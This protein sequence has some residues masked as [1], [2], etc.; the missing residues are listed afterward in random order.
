LNIH[1][2]ACSDINTERA[3]RLLLSSSGVLLAITARWVRASIAVDAVRACPEGGADRPDTVQLRA[4]LHAID[5]KHARAPQPYRGD[6]VHTSSVRAR[7]ARPQYGRR[8]P[9][10]LDHAADAI[11]ELDILAAWYGGTP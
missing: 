4:E 11:A 1:I 7:S 9:T 3:R 10:L 2:G 8:S 5:T 6:L